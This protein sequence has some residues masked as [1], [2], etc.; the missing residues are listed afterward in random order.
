VKLHVLI[1]EDD[2]M[3]A[4]DVECLLLDAGCDVCGVAA[5]E[6]EALRIGD[7]TRPPFAVVDVRLSPGDGRVAA[8][9]LFR[10]YGTA[11]L[12]AT[13]HSRELDNLAATGALACLPKPYAADGLA[14]ALQAIC[15][16]REGRRVA[17]LPKRLLP[18]NWALSIDGVIRPKARPA[19][20]KIV[21]PIKK[22]SGKPV[23]HRAALKAVLCILLSAPTI[24]KHVLTIHKW[25]K[26]A[27]SEVS[28]RSA[29]ATTAPGTRRKPGAARLTGDRRG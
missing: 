8:S 22:L 3:I 27:M 24:H 2:P 23:L 1:V 26:R 14:A 15:D 19:V 20:R 28:R 13:A 25:G 10:R 18:L 7:A 17:N 21:G 12:M 4:L 16:L 6:E 5:S 11:V 29:L 9:E